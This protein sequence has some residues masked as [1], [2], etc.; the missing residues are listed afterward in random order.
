M[1]IH[2]TTSLC[3]ICYR[4]LPGFVFEKDGS[5]FLTKTC[6]EHGETTICIEPDA[7]FFS[8]LEC[9]NLVPIKGI[10]MEVTDKCQLDCPHC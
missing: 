2:T 3:K 1:F 10:L 9:P 7:D 5:I 6:P 8:K 4:H